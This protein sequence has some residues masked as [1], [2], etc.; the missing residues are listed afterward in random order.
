MKKISGQSAATGGR[1]MRLGLTWTGAGKELRGL[2]S[3]VTRYGTEGGG[4]NPRSNLKLQSS[5]VLLVCCQHSDQW[6]SITVV[7]GGHYVE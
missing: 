3:S 5:N 6:Y 2:V 4:S 7:V 1:A